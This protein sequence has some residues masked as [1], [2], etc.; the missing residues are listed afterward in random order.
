MQVSHVLYFRIRLN[1][2]GWLGNYDLGIESNGELLTSGRP[3]L[4]NYIS[5]KKLQNNLEQ[6]MVADDNL[7]FNATFVISTE[8]P[9]C[10]EPPIATD[11][12][13]EEDKN[14]VIILEVMLGVLSSIVLLLI[15][16]IICVC[17]ELRSKKLENPKL[18][19]CD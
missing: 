19:Y 7:T 16:I 18:V 10:I 12:V 5:S 9:K 15:V 2:Y 14:L 3:P 13:P 11:T 6:V 17:R 4:I 1:M 8:L